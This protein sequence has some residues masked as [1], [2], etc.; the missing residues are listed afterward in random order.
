MSS[1]SSA[2]ELEQLAQ[3]NFGKV[4]DYLLIFFIGN[5]F[6]G[7]PPFFVISTS[8]ACAQLCHRIIHRSHYTLHILP[9]VRILCFGSSLSED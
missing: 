6:Y 1:N 5:I 9:L 7:A 2:V 8:P 3:Q 4:E